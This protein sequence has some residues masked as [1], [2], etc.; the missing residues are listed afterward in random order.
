MTMLRPF[1]FCFLPHDTAL[2]ICRMLVNTRAT[3]D[4]VVFGKTLR[5]AWSS[6]LDLTLLMNE[7]EII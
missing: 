4:L 7:K 1:P 2:A 5:P 6:G 3:T